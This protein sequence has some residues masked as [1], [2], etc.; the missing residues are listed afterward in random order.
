MEKLAIVL[1][2]DAKL[3]KLQK[4]G[5]LARWKFYLSEMSKH[6]NVEVYSCDTMDYSKELNLKHFRLPFSLNG[7]YFGNQLLYNLYLLCKAKG[8][9]RIIRVFGVG[10]FILPAIKKLFKKTIV[11]SHHYDYATTTVVDFGGMKG[12][13]AKYRQNSSLNAADTVITTTHELYNS[14]KREHG[15]DAVIIPNF[16]DTSKFFPKNK[17]NTILYAGRVYWIKGI[18]YLI[19]A[20]AR[21][22][23][24]FDV[25]LVLVGLGEIDNYRSMASEL[26]VRNITFPGAIDNNLM[27]DV[28]GRAKIF[29]LPTVTREGHPKALIEAMAS[30]CAC[31]ATN[32]PGNREL[33]KDGENGLLVN[34]KDEKSLAQ[35]MGKLLND[36]KLRIKL[37][38]SA[39]ITSKQFAL[40]NTLYKEIRLL[41]KL[42][43]E[44][45]NS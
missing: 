12:L 42:I 41:T 26:G 2:T 45:A 33:I 13:T 20:F 14:V 28:I 15:K 19:K 22:E 31:I 17:E 9:P 1:P 37:S 29:V 8:M 6:F 35:A 27:A 11:I 25:N 30:G 39:V 40:E 7:L 16:V 38:E 5:L 24:Q 32:V 23:K 10:Y 3:E 21:V 34:P 4:A 18:E 43:P 44:G 36:D